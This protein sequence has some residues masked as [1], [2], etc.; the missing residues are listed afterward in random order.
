MFGLLT[1]PIPATL[2]GEILAL[3][4]ALAL[5]PQN[6]KN[7]WHVMESAQLLQTSSAQTYNKSDIKVE[8]EEVESREE[9]Y[10]FLRGFL[11]LL[12]ALVSQ[13]SPPDNLGIGLRPKESPLG[14]QPYLQFL[15]KNVFLKSFYRPYKIASE[16]WQVTTQV[17]QI[18]LHL[19]I[20]YEAQSDAKMALASSGSQL[21]SEFTH[22]SPTARTIFLVL[23]DALVHLFEYNARNEPLVETASLAALKILSKVLEKQGRFVELLK[24]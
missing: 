15:L 3:I 24:G 19:L 22:D 13:S 23:N 21:V 10:P 11:D 8:L 18:F 9:T 5:T 17:L 14:F 1:C 7:M 12:S 16:K 6:A 20:S 2:K 4:S